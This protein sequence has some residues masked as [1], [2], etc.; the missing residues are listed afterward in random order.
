MSQRPTSGDKARVTIKVDV[1]V[2]DAFEVFTEE[3]DLWW[4]RGPRYRPIRGAAGTLCFERRV[5]G[6]LFESY[7][8]APGSPLVEIGRI[9]AWEP[10]SRLAFEWRNQTFAEGEVTF[11]EVMF[12]PTSSGSLV[13]LEHRGWAT[14]RPGHPARHGEEGSAFSVSLGLHWGS[15]LGGLR[16][17]VARR[18]TGSK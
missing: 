12:E 8:D 14:L 17:H 2:E 10:P 9:T 4:K 13:T 1:S 3:I 16:E 5:G 15:L 7:S 18:T 6:R 11:V